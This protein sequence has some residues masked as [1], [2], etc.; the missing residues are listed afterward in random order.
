MAYYNPLNQKEG[1]NYYDPYYQAQEPGASVTQ[2]LM[3]LAKTMA[4]V[5][6]LN[7]AGQSATK[8]LSRKAGS[9][10]KQHGKGRLG[11]IA[12]GM[13]T[14]N[15]TMGGIIRRT[16]TYK[17]VVKPL[18][19]TSIYK[20]GQARHQRLATLKGK[21]GY[22]AA[23]LTSAFKNPKTFL[24]ATAGVWGKN[25]LQGMGV[26]YTVD[27]ALGITAREF[28]LE[29][30]KWYDAP[31]QVSNFGKW[32]VNDSVAGLAMG[33][34]G[35]IGGALGSAGM[36]GLRKTF[37]GSFGQ[38]IMANAASAAKPAI[39]KDIKYQARDGS[40]TSVFNDV[41]QAGIRSAQEGKFAGGVVSKALAFAN[42]MPGV[43]RAANAAVRIAPQAFKS[44]QHERFGVRTKKAFNTVQQAVK[45]AWASYGKRGD[46]LRP[47]TQ[48]GGLTAVKALHQLGLDSTADS[49]VG[50]KVKLITPELKKNFLDKIEHANN[51]KSF[52][53]DV[54][55]FLKPLRNRDVV[56]KEFWQETEGRLSQRYDKT[57]VVQLLKH[58]K[59]MRAG[60]D[61]YVGTNAKGGGVDL[62]VFNPVLAMKRMVGHV[63]NKRFNVP[64]TNWSINIG[65]M[66]GLNSA[67]SQEPSFEFTRKRPAIALNDPRMDQISVGELGEGSN[68]LFMYTDGNWAVFDGTATKAVATGSRL[69]YSPRGSRAKKLQ[70]QDINLKRWEKAAAH[71]A[72]KD[73]PSGIN[74][75]KAAALFNKWKNQWEHRDAPENKYLNFL[76]TKVGLTV[77]KVLQSMASSLD[78]RLTGKGVKAKLAMG[79]LMDRNRLDPGSVYSGLPL[80]EDAYR[81]GSQVFSRILHNDHALDR[82]GM[83]MDA[84][85]RGDFLDVARND[86]SMMRFL[87]DIDW[88]ADSYVR[89]KDFKRAAD[90]IKVNPDYASTHHSVKRMGPL[91]EM[92]DFDVART[93]LIEDIFNKNFDVF[94]GNG[95]PHPILTS[96]PQ[97]EKEGYITKKEANGLSL[98][99]K[100]S[101][102]R[103]KGLFD[104]TGDPDN[105]GV[106]KWTDTIKSIR[107]RS[108]ENNWNL[109]QEILDFSRD[110]NIK[111]PRIR[112]NQ[113]KILPEGVQDFI[114]DDLPY[115]AVRPGV[116][117]L[118]DISRSAFDSTTD[119]LGEFLPFKKRD[120]THH[121]IR[122]N[123]KYVGNIIGVTAA[124]A[125]AYRTADVAVAANPLFEDTMFDDGITG[126]S[127]DVVARARLGLAHVGDLTG[128]TSAMKYLHGLAPK[129]ESFVPGAFLGGVAGAT[130]GGPF[131]AMKAAAMG[132][133]IN[134]LASPYIPDLTKSHEELERI[135]SGEEQVPVFKSPTWLLGGTPWEGT[136]VAAYQPNWYVRAKSRW[137]ESDTLYGGAFRKLI[138]KPLPL[139][140]INIGDFIDPYYMERKHFFSRPYPTTGKAFGEVP[141][142]GS[143][144][145]GTI[146]RIVKPEKTMHQE[147]LYSDT[148]VDHGPN[149]NSP[150][151]ITPPSYG[152]T[153]VMMGA[154]SPVRSTAGIANSGGQVI[155][156][157]GKAWSETAAEDFLYD[158][159]N[160]AGLKGFMAGTA[161]ERI[162][163]KETVIPTLEQAGRIS[164]MS[165]A[166]YDKNLGGMGV[167]TEPIRRL[168]DKPEYRQYGINPIPN[169]MV[170]WLP[171]HFLTGDPYCITGDT[172]VEVNGLDGLKIKPAR[173]IT[174]NDRIRTHTGNLVKPTAVKKRSMSSSEKLYRIGVTSLA[175]FPIEASEKHPIYTENGWIEI[176]DIQV[177]DYVGYPLPDE[178]E[179]T[180]EYSQIDISLYTNKD[181]PWT[182][183]H[184]Y[185]SR[186]DAEFAS[187]IYYIES[188]NTKKYK[189]GELKRILSKYNWDRSKFERAQ[190]AVKV[191][192]T[193][194]IPRY[195]NTE[196]IEWGRLIGYYLSEGHIIKSK[197]KIC[198]V[199]FSFHKDEHEY[200]NEVKAAV[201]KIFR[202]N[203]REYEHD[204]C[205][206]IQ[207]HNRAVG[208]LFFRLFGSGFDNKILIPQ[209]RNTIKETIRT[210]INGDG[211]YFFDNGK[212][213]L[214]LKLCNP[215][216]LY[217]VRHYLLT[218]GFIANI[219]DNNLIIRGQAAKDCALFLN[220]KYKETNDSSYTCTHTKIKNGY[221]WMRVFKKEII[222]NEDVYGFQVDTDDSFCTA[223]I[224]THNT[225][226]LKGELR[227][228]GCITPKTYVLTENGLAFAEDIEINDKVLTLD[229]YNKIEHI[230]PTYKNEIIY[231]ID[232]YSGL[233]VDVTGNHHVLA[234]K[235]KQC[236]YHKT[237]E[238]S[239]KRRPCKPFNNKTFCKNCLYFK[240]YQYEWVP[241]SELSEGDY[242]VLPKHI[243]TKTVT[244]IATSDIVK[245]FN[246][247]KTDDNTY[248]YTREYRGKIIFNN[249]PIVFPEIIKLDDKFMYFAGYY[250]AE[251]SIGF[252]RGKISSVSICVS[253]TEYEIL[254]NF[255]N[256]LKETYN[257]ESSII[258]SKFGNY[259]TFHINSCFF[260]YI[261][262]ELFGYNET[263]RINKNFDNLKYLL[264]GLFD[265]DAHVAKEN[266]LL[267]HSKKYIYS[268]QLPVI[269]LQEN[270][271]Y[272]IREKNDDTFITKIPISKL[273]SYLKY[274]QIESIKSNKTNTFIELDDRFLVK[275]RKISKIQYRGK[276]YDF[277]VE[278][279]HNYTTS[280]LMH[281]S[282]YSRTHPTL[283]RTMPGRASMF[284]Q[285]EVAMTRYFTGTLPPHSREGMDIMDTG[286]AMHGQIQDHLAAE[287]LLVS[288]EDLVIDVK[289][290]ITG[291]IDGIIRDGQGGRGRR[292]LE[293]KTIGDEALTEMEGPKY[294]H[295]GQ[296]NFYLRQLGL[297]SGTILYVSRDNPSNV[298]TFEVNYSENRWQKDLRK[299]QKARAAAADLMHEGIVDTTGASYSW[300]DRLNILADVAPASKEFKEAKQI[301]E[302]QLGA[303]QFTQNEIT[304]YKTALKHRQARLRSYELYPDRFRG[305][306]FSPNTQ[307]N[308]QSINED[309]KAADEYSLPSRAVGWIWEHFT[310]SNN[311]L[312]NKLF[313][314]KDPIEHYEMTRLYGKEYK[315]WDEPIR[316]WMEPYSRGLISKTGPVEGALS[317]G[318]GGFVLGGPIGAA[319]GSI[320]GSAYGSA[321]GLYRWAT[322][323]KYI[324]NIIED[325]RQL[326][327]YFDAAKYEKMG[328]LAS[329][330]DGLTKEQFM[331]AQS[332][333]LTSL[334]NAENSSVANLFRATPYTEKPYI[335]SFLN[336]HRPERRKEILNIVPK[337]LGLALSKQ[338]SKHD[339][340]IN[341]EA[342]VTNTSKDIASGSRN[343]AFNEQVMDPRVQ[344]EDIKLKAIQNRGW[345]SHEFGLGWNE[346]MLRIQNSV[347]N[348]HDANNINYND[349]PTA[350]ADV[351]PGQV[352]GSIL[353]LLHKSGIKGNANVYINNGR[354]GPN[355]VTVKIMRDRSNSVMNALRNREKYNG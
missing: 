316:S 4:V 310:N 136:K 206:T 22:G 210:L 141:V 56:N 276:V 290:D 18:K 145:A 73:D 203:C 87:D 331:S 96:L 301:V 111:T 23:R 162:F 95:K 299:L 110:F 302:A 267:T 28:G 283:Q 237:S 165:R 347:N 128:I 14:Q 231:S 134:R 149:P 125:F 33:G 198:G 58:V 228:P 207:V 99:A 282:A 70:I 127:A 213:R 108:K 153:K 221:V 312:S 168:I 196:L 89:R 97:L 157:K 98:W 104:F 82:I 191:G 226:L 37:S 200:H 186:C 350:P 212:P 86:Q 352:R 115:A 152:S 84:K 67:L 10:L 235:T 294:T 178:S 163:G 177:G 259:Y 142:I 156:P 263:K 295:V 123:L 133:V 265:G 118:L 258:K 130:F 160:F 337:N 330:S 266:I 171:S 131:A 183:T 93:N 338:W 245:K 300:L 220:T 179:W 121:G 53:Q 240:D 184:V 106:G 21:P 85:S 100:L 120:F 277:Q 201:L 187:M 138:H 271:P 199:C 17:K 3:G 102:F 159:R 24:A 257:L 1:N 342:F 229:G 307:Y 332:A 54:F 353:N 16:N 36:Q 340:S 334:V 11:S 211:S 248:R 241:T 305:Q 344:L 39:V 313:A 238:S 129:S 9:A 55:G 76:N 297:K 336:E 281:N 345:D 31:G 204:N 52:M 323:T 279:E 69:R 232:A 2:T 5:G 175:S 50:E 139:L 303:G 29:K 214:S 42:R 209:P 343:F 35:R 348:T 289:N 44:A 41:A 222:S 117:R 253:L 224:A 176:K 242:L 101:A 164:S 256:W 30:K 45:G 321:H 315:P 320:A 296:M 155:I 275:I 329:L 166:F 351:N 161:T 230:I 262:S 140:G 83:H 47:E 270:I 13:N 63:A 105:A 225:K 309:I 255:K 346:Q 60:N 154:R 113:E 51:K 68:P 174:I 243:K 195:I 126:A 288:C 233:P 273:N 48:L 192:I 244:E 182:A 317:F 308:S 8:W 88:R 314:V 304:K 137:E 62:S 324:P 311:I 272:S 349:I 264:G 292:A 116:G 234:I 122:G 172:M 65:D 254:L 6:V 252:S 71:Q 185:S 147:F 64:L 335:E 223:G 114:S 109:E 40:Y 236:K 339:Q 193:Q 169:M 103:D 247:V 280:F 167:L 250:L 274:K 355:S 94:S 34:L 216:L 20:A 43:M 188:S 57:E 326:N 32:L 268:R 180:T 150:F 151:A 80:I 251:G 27:S 77:P 205:K 341:T 135:Y 170:N 49:R 261:I 287:G 143:L 146:G 306:L 91:S 75:E 74:T 12:K 249:K 325:K 354:D 318:T 219:V 90:E 148:H 260:A 79:H 7:M 124:T 217:Q 333:T 194:R 319:V 293:I 285:D 119:L 15:P 215:L 246:I 72:M 327:N 25:V 78:D 112:A 158:I 19:R 181:L 107:Q 59:N 278:N 284:G 189:R 173:E 66:T 144:L 269:L 26:A 46:K 239:I 190:H 322:G 202:L 197:G 227:L 328:R 298:R 286:T 218:Q 291:H 92:T 132:G 38:K 208:I 61:L 81:K